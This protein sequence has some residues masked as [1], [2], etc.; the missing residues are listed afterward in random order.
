MNKKA[1]FYGFI[2]S[3]LVIAIKLSI[4][5][6][7]HSVDRFY[8][9]YAHFITVLLIIPFYAICII[10]VRNRDLNGVIGGREAMRLALTVFAV[11]ALLTSVYNYFE[12]VCSGKDL[13]IL[14]YNSQDY[15]NYLKTLK[16]VKAEDYQK[17]ITDQITLAESSGFKATTGKL[18]ALMLIGISGAVIMAALLKKRTV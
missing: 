15:L 12:F 17:I 4:L 14:H 16:N 7:G 18:F 13:A 2:Y 8:F 3:I 1:L 9:N 6:S 11:A 10:R 5:L